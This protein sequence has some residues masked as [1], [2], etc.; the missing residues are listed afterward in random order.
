MSEEQSTNEDKHALNQSQDSATQDAEEAAKAKAEEL[1]TAAQSK[2]EQGK[3]SLGS[4][5]ADEN[6]EGS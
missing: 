3:S 2:C 5:P 4:L 1:R 6:E